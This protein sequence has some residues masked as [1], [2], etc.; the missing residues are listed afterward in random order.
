MTKPLFDTLAII[1]P[2]LI[3]SSIMRAARAQDAARALR[4]PIAVTA[5]AIPYKGSF[6]LATRNAVSPRAPPAMVLAAI[7]SARPS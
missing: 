7:E 5:T 1:G 4:A 3:G 2:G 6:T